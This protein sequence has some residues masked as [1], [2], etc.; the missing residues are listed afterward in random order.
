MKN[1]TII[2]R[3]LFSMGCSFSDETEDFSLLQDTQNIL[4]NENLLFQNIKKKEKKTLNNVFDQDNLDPF[5]QLD[6]HVIKKDNVP[7]ISFIKTDFSTLVSKMR[8]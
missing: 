7:N 3:T 2:D 5:F 1:I 8:K 4:E 6:E